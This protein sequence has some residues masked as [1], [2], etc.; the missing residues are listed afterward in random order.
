MPLPP[1]QEEARIQI[2]LES[3]SD[4]PFFPTKVERPSEA[5]FWMYAPHTDDF[6]SM[7]RVGDG[8]KI[9]YPY[10]GAIYHFTGYVVS[11]QRDRVLLQQVGRLEFEKRDQRR[12]YVRVPVYMDVS[13]ADASDGSV[14]PLPSMVWERAVSRDI[15]GGGICLFVIS[16]PEWLEANTLIW[17][18][19]PIAGRD[20]PITV[21]G[22]IKQIRQ[23]DVPNGEGY[24]LGV[25]FEEISESERR[26]VIKF[27]FD[28]QRELIRKQRKG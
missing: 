8:V 17:M 5:G 23:G 15:S 28:R 24:S 9:A 19:L 27:V 18:E 20:G 21:R 11:E 12:E 4:S 16:V 2:R 10:E 26:D 22:Q 7:I 25:A 1:F 3:D 13:Y 14:L 6:R